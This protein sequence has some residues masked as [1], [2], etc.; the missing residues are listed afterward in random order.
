MLYEYL[1]HG[2]P[3]KGI[4]QFDL[5]KNARDYRCESDDVVVYW[6]TDDPQVAKSYAHDPDLGLGSIYTVELDIKK[7]FDTR[8]AECRE[9]YDRLVLDYEDKDEDEVVTQGEGRLGYAEAPV[10]YESDD[11]CYLPYYDNNNWLIPEI[12]KLGYDG[13]LVS[14]G[15]GVIEFGVFDPSRITIIDEKEI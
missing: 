7:L 10:P 6:A 4:K 3:T 9:I 5:D 8:N 12:Q 14:P 1:Y 11:Y 2:S 15:G 13:L